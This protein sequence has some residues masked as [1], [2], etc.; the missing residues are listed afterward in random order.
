[1]HG[2]LEEKKLALRM[3]DLARKRLMLQCM[4]MVPWLA[5]ASCEGQKWPG[6]MRGS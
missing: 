6:A 5:E 3:V 1:M 4:A 2:C